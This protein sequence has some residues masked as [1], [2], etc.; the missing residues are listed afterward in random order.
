MG[1]KVLFI[2][3][4][5][6]G[7]N[8]LPP[9][10]AMFSSILKAEGHQVQI[11]DSTYYNT[12][13]GIDSDGSKMER[14]NVVPFKMDK[15]MMAL[16]V[17]DWREDLKK[18]VNEFQPN[19]IAISATEDMWE[20]GVKIVNEVKEYKI[21][22]K[23]PVIA[24]GV[25]ATFAPDLC[26]KEELIDLVCVGEGENA[27]VD[28]CKKIENNDDDFTDITNCWVKKEGKIIKKNSIT[29]PVDINKSPIIDI[30]LFE[31]ARLHRPMSG[32]V[33]KM[34][35]VET[36]RGC[37][38]TC[39]FCNS[40]D[41]MKLYKGL[42]S[43]FYRKKKMD[44]VYK[45]LKYFKDVQ[46][47]EYNYFWADT[48]LGMSSVEFEEF[49]EM[50]ED[51]KLPF[52]MQTRPETINDYNMK[53][54]KSVGLHRVSFGLEHGNEEFRKKILDRRWKNK[55]IIDKLKIPKKYDI[56]F[57]VNN[58]TG[59]PTETKKLAFDTIEINREIDADNANIYAFV[60]F[61]G[62][63]LRKMCEDLGLIK[64]EV[65][66]KCLTAESQ[67]NMPQYPPHEIEEIKKCFTLY[68]KFPK[69]R[70]KEIERAEKNDEEGNRIYKLLKAE[71][72]EKYMPAPDADPH[73][74]Q[75]DFDALTDPVCSVP[76]AARPKSQ[77]DEMQ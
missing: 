23:V 62:T 10:I 21:K 77:K 40:P 56:S 73:G 55:D 8:M 31:E 29:K 50:Y 65:I 67:L 25:F 41:Q 64:H 72:L 14:L 57:S 4:N 20:L 61:H 49:C 71:Y 32:R 6:Y 18:Q 47:V 43:N 68:V 39:T 34:L 52:W 22:N 27:L 42:G 13:H 36:I 12:D 46:K 54:L 16:K 70:W 48:F 26:M 5:T 58:I 1:I 2:Y 51:I 66:T 3:P 9:A 37:P 74:G 28:L 60:P 53:K 11:F 35:P 19:L 59:F 69:N 30:S 33:Y 76:A 38:F 24:G 7:M 45:E 17:T 15:K 44:L 75:E 63:P